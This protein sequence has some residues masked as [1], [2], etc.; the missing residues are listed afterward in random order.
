VKVWSAGGRLCC[1]SIEV[2]RKRE[3]ITGR[4]E[5]RASQTIRTN[6][7]TAIREIVDPIEDTTFHVV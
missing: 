4:P 1:H 2:G 6:P 5:I 7:I 3:N